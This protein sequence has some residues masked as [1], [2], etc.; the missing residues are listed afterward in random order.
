MVQ[1]DT[2]VRD[3]ANPSTED[4]YFPFSRGYDFYHGHSWARGVLESEN[5]KDQESSAEDAFS[6]YAIKMWGRTSGDAVMEARG[7]LQLA[8]TA[9]S[10]QSYY[11]YESDNTVQ[12]PEFIGVKAAGILFDRAINHTT[13]F[14]DQVSFVQGIHMLP[15]N[16]SSAYTRRARFVREE[17]DQYFAGNKSG[18]LTGGGFV[19][20]VYVNLAIADVAGARE[21][22]EF[23]SRQRV[24]GSL[25]DGMSLAWNLAYTAALG[26]G[27]ASNSTSNSTLRRV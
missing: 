23:M 11:L 12:P 26:G 18:A 25:T 7:N 2:L 17:W 8:I 20:H 10:L 16:P 3:W 27:L 13:Y 24:N 15:I 19:G 21:S 14:G 22:Y 4:P 5:G 9:R 6:T 1:V